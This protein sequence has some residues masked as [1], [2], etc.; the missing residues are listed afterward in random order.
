MFKTVS[1]QPTEDNSSLNLT[2]EE[3]PMKKTSHLSDLFSIKLS[4]H[5]NYDFIILLYNFRF[6]SM[7]KH[8]IIID[9]FKGHD[10]DKKK[11][12]PNSENL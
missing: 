8:I 6:Y 2:K 10:W 7:K 1:Q 4:K 11:E 3:Q 12:A 9:H 5:F